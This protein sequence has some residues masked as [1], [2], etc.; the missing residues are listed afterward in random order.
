MS[1]AGAVKS[2]SKDDNKSNESNIG[3]LKF[4]KIRIGFWGP[5]Y[6]NYKKELRKPKLEEDLQTTIAGHRGK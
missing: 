1:E 4:L 2:E 6:Y 5:V 3:A